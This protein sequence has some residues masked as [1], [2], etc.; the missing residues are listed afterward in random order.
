MIL[1]IIQFSDECETVYNMR[2]EKYTKKNQKHIRMTDIVIKLK[3]QGIVFD[4]V[5]LIDG[6]EQLS[7]EVLKTLNENS[8]EVYADLGPSFNEAIAKIE[9]E[10]I[11]RVFSR[12]PED[13]LFL[14]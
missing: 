12:V 7:N 11:N 1:K 2:C 5:N 6:N 3:P 9:K 14:P 4:F 10:I 8:M 13:E